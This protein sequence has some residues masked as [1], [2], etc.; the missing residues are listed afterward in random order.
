MGACALLPRIVGQGRAAELLLTGRSLPG[1]E[2]ERWGFFN[3]LCEPAALLGEARAA[4]AVLAAGP[5]FAHAMTK[6]MLD[7]EW[8][9]G[10]AE[11]IEAEAQAQAICMQTKDF[12][13]AYEAFV[14]KERPAF[15][16]D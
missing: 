14:R 2:A 1:E 5:T 12:A 7:Q 15:E 3:R 16:G 4:A 10:L 8:A 13:R 11:A 9:M 6:R